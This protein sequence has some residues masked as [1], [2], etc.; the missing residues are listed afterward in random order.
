MNDSNQSVI[1]SVII[2]THNRATLLSRA[3]QS[4]LAQTFTDF[5][6]IVVDDVSSDNTSVVVNSFTDSRIIY[7]QRTQNGGAA[8][9]RNT[10]IQQAHGI[11]IAFLDDDDE[12]QPSFLSKMY[13]AFEAAN[14]AVG[15]GWC[16]ISVVEDSYTG[17]VLVSEGAWR[18]KYENREHAYLSFM[19][20][21]RI[22]TNC[23]ITIRRTCFETVGLF[24]ERMRKAEDTD[25]LTRMVR[26]FDFVV[27]PECLV[28]VHRHAGL[29]LT[30]YDQQMAAAYE[31]I[32]QKN[33]D[34]LCTHP[35]LWAAL[36]YKTGWLYYHGG[37][38]A[39]AR[40]HMRKVLQSNPFHMK[41]W[42]GLFLHE[43]LGPWAP[44]LHRQISALKS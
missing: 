34:T 18:P 17:S 44:R 33:L 15:L 35:N 27:V 7:V 29:R 20:T 30:V 24:D 9:T 23:G 2:P 11:Y 40:Y 5:E 32:I 3:I 38:K 31:R 42:L 39:K 6:L 1:F 36:H 21:R 22:G 10:G 25:F 14:E 12:Y 4:V 19:Q 13:A 28:K 26:R 16:G 8:A 43:I 37:N 41:T